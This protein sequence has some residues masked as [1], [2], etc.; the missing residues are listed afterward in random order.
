MKNKIDFS[1]KGQIQKIVREN[2]GGLEEEDK[3]E[4]H[5]DIYR[6]NFSM[7]SLF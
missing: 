4:Q 3:E 1:E 7:L 5:Y 2:Y 6:N